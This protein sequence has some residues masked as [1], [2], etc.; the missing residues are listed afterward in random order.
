MERSAFSRDAEYLYAIVQALPR[1]WRPPGEGLGGAPVLA[2]PVRDVVL[3]TS[4]LMGSLRPTP[5]TRAAHA[6]VVE[7][8]TRA[9]AILPMAFGTVLPDAHLV[10]WLCA[11]LPLVRAG[12][13]R[14]RG[15]AEMQVRLVSLGGRSQNLEALAQRVVEAAGLPTW[16]YCQAPRLGAAS[17]AF[18][19]PRPE[20]TTFLARIAPI[21]S[22]TEDVAVVPSGPLPP[23]SFTPCL[24]PADA[25]APVLAAS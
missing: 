9:Q 8:A 10:P 5:L 18:L 20:V 7:A 1:G 14:V 24:E 21:A 3:I 16:S 11:R 13:R 25:P 15:A 4:H 2:V 22:R 6:D 19:V 12:L 17:L 23:Y